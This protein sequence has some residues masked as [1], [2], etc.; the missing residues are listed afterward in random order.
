MTGAGEG[1][2]R[3]SD[4]GEAVSSSSAWRGVAMKE[5]AARGSDAVGVGVAPSVRGKARMR[6]RIG[7]LNGV[8][9]GC[10]QWSAASGRR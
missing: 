3:T 5:G 4:E 6:G 9:G 7:V 2:E 10:A 1:T 8:G